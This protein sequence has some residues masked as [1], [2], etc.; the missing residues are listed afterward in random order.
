MR[1]IMGV[2]TV[3]RLL[4]PILLLVGAARWH[5]DGDR[6]LLVPLW[7]AAW[8]ALVQYPFA[9]P[10]YF[11]YAFPLL[12]LAVTAV[13]VAA[14]GTREIAIGA[15]SALTLWT[16]VVSHGQTIDQLAWR[17]HPHPPVFTLPGPHGG[18]EVPAWD[19][20]AYG[21]LTTLLEEWGATRIVAGPDAPDVYYLGGHPFP[22]R[23][24]FEFMAPEWS[25]AVLARRIVTH[26]AQAAVLNTR[27]GFSRVSLDSVV[28]LLPAP[29]LADTLIG[30]F[31]VLRLP[32]LDASP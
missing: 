22:D 8:F 26:R 11:V 17:N 15:G 20:D 29:P 5:R 32:A 18:L 30:R 4:A 16:L 25:A 23:E 12:L 7:V 9:A 3:L 6:R 27:P 10:I 13:V 1:V 19:A 2:W 21:R 24:F 14:G 31:R 28:A